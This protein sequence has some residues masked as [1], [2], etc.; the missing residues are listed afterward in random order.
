[1]EVPTTSHLLDK[2]AGE[3]HQKQSGNGKIQLFQRKMK[4]HELMPSEA[5][6]LLQGILWRQYE[7]IQG[8]STHLQFVVPYYLQEEILQQ[9]HA[10]AMGGLLGVKKKSGKDKGEFFLAWN[11]A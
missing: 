8:I 1:M 11:T 10:G 4:N 3:L 6:D 7:D 2:S 9:F 5:K